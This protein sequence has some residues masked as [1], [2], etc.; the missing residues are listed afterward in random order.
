MK[1]IDFK[2]EFKQLYAASANKVDIL[3]VPRMTMLMIDSEGNPTEGGKFDTAAGAIY[4]IAYCLK[5]LL[6]K[7]KKPKGY[8]D[9]V[10]PPFESVWWA[11]SGAFDVN[12]SPDWRWRLL[13]RQ[14]DYVSKA[15]VK[16][17]VKELAKK[18]EAGPLN[19]VRLEKFSEGLCAQTLHLGSYMEEAPTI[20]R[21]M[22]FLDNEG[23]TIRGNHHE[24]YMS[25][26]HRV[27]PER[28]KTIL[29]Y[30]IK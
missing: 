2:K 18:R 12:N 14:P 10:V 7:W 5:S 27:P 19:A 9:Y 28:L 21:I 24:I 26:P 15:M 13:L 23:Y 20:K 11:E 8:Y 4:G 3:K 22:E 17:A 30:P 16:D 29:R 25:N 1:K 6:K